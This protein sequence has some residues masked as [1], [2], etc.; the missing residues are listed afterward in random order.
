MIG[1]LYWRRRRYR[2]ARTIFSSITQG[3]SSRAVAAVLHYWASLELRIGN[4][5]LARQKL[6]EAL[7]KEPFHVSSLVSLAVL[8]ARLGPICSFGSC[9]ESLS[10]SGH[11]QEAQDL[12]DRAL[13]VDDAN[14]HLQNSIAQFLRQQGEKEKAKE[15]LKRFID[16]VPSCGI[17][18]YILGQMYMEEGAWND[19]RECYEQGIQTRRDLSC[20]C[21]IGS[22]QCCSVFRNEGDAPVSGGPS[23]ST[24]I[25]RGS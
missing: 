8:E 2:E 9:I 25:S 21:A 13:S 11:I 16:R 14:A 15:H 19:A 22:S 3:T 4:K 12:Y 7:N 10:F 17:S 5:D 6:R 23:R 1:R 24:C 20:Y 18:W